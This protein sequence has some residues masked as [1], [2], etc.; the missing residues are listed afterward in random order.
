[1]TFTPDAD[2]EW[3]VGLDFDIVFEPDE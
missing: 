1:V 2:L 3:A